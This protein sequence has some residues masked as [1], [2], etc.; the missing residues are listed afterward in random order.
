MK[1]AV[2]VIGYTHNKREFRYRHRL[3]F[4]HEL[5][6]QSKEPERVK[7]SH[8]SMEENSKITRFTRNYKGIS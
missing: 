6:Q 5:I 4:F 1:V 3:C 7:E 2:F 8:R